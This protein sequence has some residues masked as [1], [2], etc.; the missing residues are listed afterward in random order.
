MQGYTSDDSY[1]L[2]PLDT[3][4]DDTSLAPPCGSEPCMVN[5]IIEIAQISASDVV[6]DLG[7]GDGRICFAA[8]EAGAHTVV[9]VEIIEEVCEAFRK[10]ISEKKVEK[11]VTCICGDLRNI[12]Y[13]PATV[14]LIYLLPDALTILE[15][16]ILNMLEKRNEDFRV[17][18][19][20]WGFKNIEPAEKVVVRENQM[21]VTFFVYKGKQPQ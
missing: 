19:N 17:V 1:E 13:S 14:L 12:D 8:Q 15:P 6:Y 16:G 4:V 5:R 10:K 7:A 18:C 3:Y 20:S 2:N 9:G 11:T 21:E